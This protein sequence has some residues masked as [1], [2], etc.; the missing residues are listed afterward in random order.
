MQDIICSENIKGVYTN[1][2]SIPQSSNSDVV[3]TVAISE[4][5]VYLGHKSPIVF[6]NDDT[7]SVDISDVLVDH[8]QKSPIVIVNDDTSSVDILDV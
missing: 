4:D 2:T 6:V 7:S 3:D 1:V 5:L 8:G